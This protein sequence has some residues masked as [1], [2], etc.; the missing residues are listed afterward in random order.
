MKSVLL[1]LLLL[2][3]RVS[4]CYHVKRLMRSSVVVPL[5]NSADDYLSYMT[6]SN[7]ID[8]IPLA[9]LIQDDSPYVNV[10]SLL[11]YCYYIDHNDDTII[12]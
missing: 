1:L 4:R 11:L 9:Q 2:L 5:H 3:I 7:D 12:R 6:S 8:S 10:V